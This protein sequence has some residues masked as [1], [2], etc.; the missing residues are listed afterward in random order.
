MAKKHELK[1][2]EVQKENKA[3]K[4]T[5]SEV[6]EKQGEAEKQADQA[7]QVADQMEQKVA[8]QTKENELLER[9]MSKE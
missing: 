7:E 1:L 3:L 2:E 8:E 4:T 5:L 6:K 9:Q